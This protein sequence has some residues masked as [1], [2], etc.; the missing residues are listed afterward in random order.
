MKPMKKG[1]D[2][3]YKKTDKTNEKFKK[4]KKN[5]SSLIK[6]SNALPVKWKT[7]QFFSSAPIDL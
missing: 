5:Q 1:N 4:A 7:F 3:K 6:S 2:N